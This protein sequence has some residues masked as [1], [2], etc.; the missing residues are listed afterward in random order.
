MSESFSLGDFE[1]RWLNGGRF[2]L[3]GG[4]MFG[5]VPRKLWEKKY[6]HDEENFITL[7]AS[8]ILIKTPGALI[9]IETGIGNKLTEKQRSIF[10]VREEWNIINDLAG[11]G[12]S[13][14]DVDY[15]ILTHFDF[16]HAGGITMNEDQNITLT[17]PNARHLIQKAD[18]EDAL[19]PG[20]RAA[21]SYWPINYDL[22][23]DSR[24]L[25]LIDGER[26]VIRGVK[27]ILTGGHHRGHQM[28]ILES[29]DNKVIHMGD[30]LPTHAHYNPLWVMAYDDFPLDVI[31]LKADWEEKASA[32]GAWF[33]FYHDPFV[34]VCRFDEKGN[35]IEK[36]PRD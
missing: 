8:P 5:V 11:L 18:W 21:G 36:W 33:A 2:E 22:L 34:K 29:G 15:V 10:R 26:E 16:D 32:E 6:P 3:D 31:R 20:R 12:F 25:Q 4:A 23:K 24:N 35:I 30:L 9:L 27:C 7:V 17:F 14:K 1:L 28:V 13:R 19:K